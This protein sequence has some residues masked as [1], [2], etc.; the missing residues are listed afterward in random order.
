MLKTGDCHNET[1]Y[2]QSLTCSALRKLLTS[3][4]SSSCIKHTS[5]EISADLDSENESQTLS[6]SNLRFLLSD[7]WTE[8]K[9]HCAL[10]WYC[11][12]CCYCYCY[13][14]YYYYCYYYHHHFTFYS[15]YIGQPALA[16]APV[17][18]Y[19]PLLTATCTF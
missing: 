15:H 6:P 17:K 7:H 14:Y 10:Y 13:C 18:N 11:Y 12:Y 19:V 1:L 16:I 5:D 3:F 8:C 9:L 4:A 2:E